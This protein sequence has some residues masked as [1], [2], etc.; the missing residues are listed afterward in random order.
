MAQVQVAVGFGRKT[1]AHAGRIGHALGMMFGIAG[2]S[3][4]LA[5]GVGALFKV[6][7]DD[8]AQEIAG[9][10]RLFIGGGIHHW[11]LEGRTIRGRM[12]P[13]S[14]KPCGGFGL[15]FGTIFTLHRARNLQVAR[16]ITTT[17]HPAWAGARKEYQM[18]MN[19]SVFKWVAAGVLAAG[20]LG[21]A[22]TASAG[23]SWSVNVGVPGV[24]VAPAPVYYPP[25]P[26]YYAPPP[27]VYYRPAP[28]YYAPPPVYY[29]PA[30][31]YIQGGGYYRHGP[32]YY[33]PR[34]RPVYRY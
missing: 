2:R 24:V 12:A 19:R 32:R 15:P 21:A 10:G 9:L 31:V 6:V 14:Y 4:P 18:T 25:A 26:V 1:Q 3:T 7:L 23:V 16:S 22:A 30:P 29:R 5:G 34:P 17:R 13:I 8:V 27:P 11:I 33:G 20:A 28:V